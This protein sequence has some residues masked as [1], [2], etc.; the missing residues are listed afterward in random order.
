MV[1]R[2]R[3][4]KYLS[5]FHFAYPGQFTVIEIP[6]LQSWKIL[7]AALYLVNAFNHNDVGYRREG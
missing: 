3:P 2:K 7:Y 6:T 4:L 1:Q 5:P